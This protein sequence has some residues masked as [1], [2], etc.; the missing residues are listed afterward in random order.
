MIHQYKQGGQCIVLDA[1]SGAI[2]LV[3]AV[4]YDIIALKDKQTPDETIV[5]QML[6]Q[7]ADLDGVD[8]AEIRACL[9]DIEALRKAGKLFSE[10]PLACAPAPMKGE[11]V[12]KALCLHVAHTC[13]LNCQYCFARQG[14][15]HGEEALMSFDVGKQALDLL[16]RASG[17][18]V[19]LEVDFFGGEPLL[20][21]PVVKALVAYARSQEQQHNKQFRFTFTTNGLLLDDE[22]ID[23]LN[24]EMHNVVLSLDGRP[25]VHDALRKNFAG[26]GSY[27]TVVPKFRKLVE[28][29]GGKNYYMRGTFT[30]NNVDFLQDICHMADL[31]FREL[32]ME[33]VVC[34]PAEDY[35]LREEDLPLL[36]AQYEQLAEEMLR[37]EAR[38]EGF[39]FY[40]YMLD[41]AG[42]PC[43]PKRLSGCGSGNEYMAVTP[44]GE[45]Y[46]CHQFV[47]E[48][49]FCMGHVKDGIKNTAL[50][51]AFLDCNIC[52]NETCRDCWAKLFCAGGCA[53]NAYHATG[54]IHGIYEYGC[55]LF[56][57]RVECAIYLQA[58]R[59]KEPVGAGS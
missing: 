27:E 59:T 16:I 2:H 24:R 15:Y 10:D 30:R 14:N 28:A 36:M 33:P 17:S 43:L 47:G 8:E 55:T 4:A 25:E 34:D 18:R 21:W 29:R 42:G 38:G 56:K 44:T 53:A 1:N 50:Q 11:P 32:S 57:K 26:Q 39:T 48:D 40:H 41:L 7:Y 52:Q 49:T 23:F 35:A 54:S 6:K 22:V 20:N 12:L 51:A 58:M 31:G 45:L 13:N 3:D 9:S 5:A 37:R 19:H 46:P